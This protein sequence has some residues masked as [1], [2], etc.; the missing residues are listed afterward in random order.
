MGW[1]FWSKLPTLINDIELKKDG[2]ET[3]QNK[4]LG[5]MLD[6]SMNVTQ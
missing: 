3:S 1:K 5:S 6:D 2:S 4:L